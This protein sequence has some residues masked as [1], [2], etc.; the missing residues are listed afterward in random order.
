MDKI[1]ELIKLEEKRQQETLTLIASENYPFPEVLNT[2][3]SRL[4]NKYSEGY[5]G[6]RYYRG[7]KYIDEIE[8]LAIE[9]AKKL[10]GVEYS[11][12][13]PY[14]GSP[15]NGEAIMAMVEPGE[16]IMGMKLSG[17]GHLTHGHPKITFSGKFFESVQYDVDENGFIDYDEVERLAIREK[18]KLMIVGTTAYPRILDF[19]R[20]SQIAHKI[21]AYLLADISH[22]VGLVVAGVHPSP[23]S[24]ADVIMTTTHKSLRGPRG[25]ILMTNDD[26]LAKKIDKA[27]FPGMQGGPHNATTA[28]IAVCLELAG[29]PEFKKYGQ[30]VVKNAQ[31]LAQELVNYGLKLT[32]GGTDNHLMVVDL[33]GGGREI[34]E[35]LEE[36]GIIV[37]ANTVPH[38]IN[39]PTNPG[40]IRLGTPAVTTRG[41]KEPEM[42]ILAEVIYKVISGQKVESQIEDL[43]R[44]FPI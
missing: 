21:G 44:R 36:I 25:A 24:L 40:G 31:V 15:A 39:P 20:F 42:K 12:V 38:D 4:N 22:I 41:M 2:Q 35:K 13:Q 3:C 5:P 27:V 11:N 29:K 33:G 34:A 9:R 32:T 26:N 8:N 1:F 18:P 14:S 43:C 6:K 16:K 28:G 37:N 30:Q 19:E 10:F 23:V 7:N 17:G